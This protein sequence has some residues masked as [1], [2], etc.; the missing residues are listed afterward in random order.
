[1]HMRTIVSK[2][3]LSQHHYDL[4]DNFVSN[5]SR[6]PVLPAVARTDMVNIIL[7]SAPF[8]LIFSHFYSI[9]CILHVPGIYGRLEPVLDPL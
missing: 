9:K 2:H 6:P 1:M 5:V 4:Y 3:V 8:W 7:I